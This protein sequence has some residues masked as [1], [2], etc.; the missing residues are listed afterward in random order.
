M[1]GHP[2]LHLLGMRVFPRLSQHCKCWCLRV[3]TAAFISDVLCCITQSLYCYCHAM[4]LTSFVGCA[5]LH[6][7]GLVHLLALYCVTLFICHICVLVTACVW[8][9]HAHGTVMCCIFELCLGVFIVY[10]QY[11]MVSTPFSSCVCDLYGVFC[12]LY[13][14]P[15]CFAPGSE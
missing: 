3:W 13:V 5:V 6:P 10:I 15:L 11:L 12:A 14:P 8:Q 1:H 9:V 7:Q 2:Q 4:S